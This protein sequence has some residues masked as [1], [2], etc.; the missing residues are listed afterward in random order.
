MGSGPGPRVSK[1]LKLAFPVVEI[2]T[3]TGVTTK[4]V[5]IRR[6]VIKGFKKFADDF[7][8]FS[9]N[10]ID[11]GR[12]VTVSVEFVELYTLCNQVTIMGAEFLLK[13]MQLLASI[14]KADFNGIK[15]NAK[16]ISQAG[17]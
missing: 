14:F 9:L 13:L 5:V 8:C 16:V 1:V 12:T 4:V 2:C 3:I 6:Q 10:R 11:I 15:R 7:P 17:K